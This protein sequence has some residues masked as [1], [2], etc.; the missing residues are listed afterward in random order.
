MPSATVNIPSAANTTPEP[1]LVTKLTRGF[2]AKLGTLIAAN[3]AVA[4]TVPE[5]TYYNQGT[6]L[7][8]TTGAQGTTA[9]LEG[10]IDGGVTWFVLPAKTSPALTI[11]GQLTGDTAA[12][13]AAVYDISGMG[14]GTLFKFGYAG[15]GVPTAVVWAQLG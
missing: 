13:F 6:V 10:S 12:T 1:T 4:F 11:T 14:S 5:P 9:T 7:I 2:P 8:Q 15:A 3:T